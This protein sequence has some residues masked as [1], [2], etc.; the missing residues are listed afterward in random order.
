MRRNLVSFVVVALM[1]GPCAVHPQEQAGSGRFTLSRDD[2]LYECFPD[3][4]RL[5]SGRLICVYRESDSHTSAAFTHLV[6]RLSDDDGKTWPAKFLLAESKKADGVLQKWNCPRVVQLRDGR[7]LIL[8]D[9]YAIPPGES[10][11]RD[12][13]KVFFWFS[14]DEGKTFSGPRE[15]PIVGIVPDRLLELPDGAWLICTHQFARD[16]DYREE[17]AWRSE[18]QGRTW[19]GPFTI[20]SKPGLQLCEGSIVRLP[21]GLLV[22]YLRENSGQGLPAYKSFSRDGGRTWDGPYETRI[23]GCHRPVAGLL[24]SG[25]VLV[26]YRH[27]PD[28]RPPK[29][30]FAFLEP[31]ASAAEM[32][33]DK[34]RGVLLPLDHDRHKQADGGY[35]GWVLLPDGRILVVNY[36]KDDAPMAQIRGYWI[37]ESDF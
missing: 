37:R 33:R 36:I 2:S 12:Y 17:R 11:R 20:A 3:L 10:A 16:H 28:S 18:D 29:N 25:H 13:S 23:D 24:P 31:A 9:R 30:T 14:Q 21:D 5:R 32:S 15:T 34:Q 27:K 19:Q 4:A 26:T 8:C 6:Y 7:L 22:C 1:M 35:T